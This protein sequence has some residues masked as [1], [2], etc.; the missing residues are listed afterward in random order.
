[1]NFARSIDINAGVPWVIVR[2]TGT[3]ADSGLNRADV[4]P[5]CV[6]KQ[7]GGASH[8]T[9]LAADVGE[10]LRHNILIHLAA[11]VDSIRHPGL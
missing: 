4:I 7:G 1:M 2:C 9:G 3:R 6:G 11:V 5:R 10:S 8:Q